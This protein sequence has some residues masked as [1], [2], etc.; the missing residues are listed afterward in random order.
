MVLRMFQALAHCCVEPVRTSLLF[1]LADML[2][3][4]PL[5]PRA[6]AP[7]TPSGGEGPRPPKPGLRRQLPAR[8]QL[9]SNVLFRAYTGAEREHRG[10][11]GFLQSRIHTTNLRRARAR[12][13]V[14][15]GM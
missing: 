1:H 14:G 13:E 11:Q 12:G 8:D 9:E 3:E 5:E 10:Q 7:G 2:G 6:S 15:R 4:P